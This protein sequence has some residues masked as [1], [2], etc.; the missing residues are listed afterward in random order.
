MA[1]LF[2][3]TEIKNFYNNLTSNQLLAIFNQGATLGFSIQHRFAISFGSAHDS[4]NHNWLD[5]MK[6]IKV[7]ISIAE[8]FYDFEGKLYTNVE[9]NADQILDMLLYCMGGVIDE[10]D[11]E[12]ERLSHLDS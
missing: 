4:G 9:P 6:M 12:F 2:K 10:F 8:C 5:Q 1:N 3:P 11:K 7:D